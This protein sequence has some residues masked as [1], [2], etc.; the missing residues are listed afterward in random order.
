MLRL[1]EER[2]ERQLA[3]MNRIECF[4]PCFAG[5]LPHATAMA[6]PYH[7]RPACNGVLC[8]R[9]VTATVY[10]CLQG[11]DSENDGASFGRGFGNASDDGD[12]VLALRCETQ[13]DGGGAFLGS[14]IASD[15]PISRAFFHGVW[16]F[17]VCPWFL[18]Q[19]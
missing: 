6:N 11:Y 5:Y 14:E 19:P 15:E 13:N 16:N 8:P 4:I 18:M 1:N 2:N 10:I 3:N 7:D 9:F 12:D 17:D